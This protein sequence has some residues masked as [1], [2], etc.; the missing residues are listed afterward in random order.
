[1]ALEWQA[2]TMNTAEQVPSPPS[3]A[4]MRC[5]CCGRTGRAM[6][7]LGVTPGVFICRGCAFY[8]FRFAD[9][10]GGHG[11]GRRRLRR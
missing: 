8:A 4:E 9:K 5:G 11:R 7:E 6:H 3:P 2:W 1:V 10:D